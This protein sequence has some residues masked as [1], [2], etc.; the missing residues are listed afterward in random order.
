MLLNVGYDS[1]SKRVMIITRGNG[2]DMY[3]SEVR[4]ASLYH[5]KELR[6]LKASGVFLWFVSCW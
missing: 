4:K 5:Q 3:K 1:S 2:L 6:K